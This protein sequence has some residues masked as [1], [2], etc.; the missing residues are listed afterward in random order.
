MLAFC[1]HPTRAGATVFVEARMASLT[2]RNVPE[3]VVEQIKNVAVRN[4]RSMESEVRELLARQFARSPESRA[5]VLERIRQLTAGIRPPTA[6]QIRR[7]IET[8]RR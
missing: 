2:I 1:L 8:G 4:G 7:W 5:Q 3:E 6:R